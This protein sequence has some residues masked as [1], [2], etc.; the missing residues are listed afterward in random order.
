MHPVSA[1]ADCKELRSFG[2]LFGGAIYTVFGVLL[3]LVYGEFL[4]GP[5]VHALSHPWPWAAGLAV[6]AWALLH[7]SSLDWLHALWMKFADVMGW[8]NTRIIL[9]LVFYVLVL[10]TGLLMRLVGRDPMRRKFDPAASSYRRKA[11]PRDPQ[12]MRNPY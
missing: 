1:K 3:P 10:P 9:A 12:H 4:A 11:V 2:L 7:P 6:Q 5:L 8:I